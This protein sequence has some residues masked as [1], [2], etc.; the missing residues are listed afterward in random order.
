M[1]GVAVEVVE[2]LVGVVEAVVRADLVTVWDE[3]LV[4]LAV[5]WV[6]EWLEDL[7][8]PLLVECLAGLDI[9]LTRTP[10]VRRLVS[11]PTGIAT[12]H[13]DSAAR[14]MSKIILAG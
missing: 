9:D 12:A 13:E 11:W 6:E 4:D 5:I 8:M 1:L 2:V 10:A 7:V 3:R 14:L